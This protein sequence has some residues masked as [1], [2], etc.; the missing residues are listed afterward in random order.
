MNTNAVVRRAQIEVALERLD[1]LENPVAVGVG[2]AG[3][4]AYVA[5]QFYV[6]HWIATYTWLVPLFVVGS[7]VK[8]WFAYR[9]QK[10]E[11]EKREL[12]KPG[13]TAELPEARVVAVPAAGPASDGRARPAVDRHP[14]VPVASIASVEPPSAAPPGETP[15]FLK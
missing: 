4:L 7:A 1:R 8:L 14:V 15:S 2:I 10:L 5:W 12:L 9:S 11:R 3:A 13:S 6:N